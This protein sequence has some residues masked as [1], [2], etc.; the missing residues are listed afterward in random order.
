MFERATPNNATKHGWAPFMKRP[1]V[2]AVI[3]EG[4]AKRYG[5]R[6][7]RATL[8]LVEVESVPQ[9]D[10]MITDR[11]RMVAKRGRIVTRNG[12]NLKSDGVMLRHLD[13]HPGKLDGH[14]GKTAWSSS[15]RR[16]GKCSMTL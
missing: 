8:V 6:T 13:N 10:N 3:D 15:W 4:L 7:R 5:R 12:R 16:G 11:C 14:S 1:M 2:H 9:C